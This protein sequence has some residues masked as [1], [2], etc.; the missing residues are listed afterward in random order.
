MHAFD[1]VPYYITFT[2]MISAATNI[3][4][5]VDNGLDK[6]IYTSHR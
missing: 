4:M 6:F 3:N 2:T 1:A 5:S